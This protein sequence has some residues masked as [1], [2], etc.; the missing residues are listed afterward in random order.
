MIANLVNNSVKYSRPGQPAYIRITSTEPAPGWVSVE[1][2][3]RG[4][5]I[6][7]GEEEAI[8]GAYQRSDKDATTHHGIGLGLSLCAEIV[9]RH[10]GRIRAARNAW[11]GATFTFTLPGGPR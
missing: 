11:D 6:Q 7:P 10:G 2:A 4:V 3:D 9:A 8:F 5:G 1:V